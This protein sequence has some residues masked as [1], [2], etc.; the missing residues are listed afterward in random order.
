M[1]LLTR[2]FPFVCTAS[3]IKMLFLDFYTIYSDAFVQNETMRRKPLSSLRKLAKLSGVRAS[4]EDLAHKADTGMTG[5]HLFLKSD[6]RID[7]SCL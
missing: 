3:A 7:T 1:E 6:C 4:G 2:I 5:K